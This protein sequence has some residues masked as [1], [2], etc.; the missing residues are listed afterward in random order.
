MQV[1]FVVR[2]DRHT[3]DEITVHASLEDANRAFEAFKALY[4]DTE[5]EAHDIDEWV[6]YERDECEDGPKVRIEEAEF[7]L[8]PALKI[9]V[10]VERDFARILTPASRVE[11]VAMCQGFCLA[12]G[13]YRGTTAMYFLPD[14]LEEMNKEEQPSEVKLALEEAGIK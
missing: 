1:F 4:D 10:F 7:D 3:D 11:A 12:A 14:N 2:E 9:A 13:F 5:W 6:R 8:G